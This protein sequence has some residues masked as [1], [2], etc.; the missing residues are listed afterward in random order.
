MT[1]EIII[2]GVNVAG[3]EFYVKHCIEDCYD[4]RVDLYEYCQMFGSECINE[5]DCYYKQLRRLKQ[6]NEK[7]KEQQRPLEVDK[8]LYDAYC[9]T[10]CRA[11]DI[12][13]DIHKEFDFISEDKIIPIIKEG[14]RIL[15]FQ[16]DNYRKALEEIREIA[17]DTFLCCDDDCGNARKIKLIIDEINEV[18]G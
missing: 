3:C 11:N 8:K 10:H 14:I 4:E 2:D 9:K 1:E 7:L 6:E 16:R 13:I 5:K 17:D 12:A 15:R 18:L